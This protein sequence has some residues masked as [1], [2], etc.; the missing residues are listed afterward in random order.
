M[1]RKTCSLRGAGLQQGICRAGGVNVNGSPLKAISLP[2][3]N[4]S[5]LEGLP[6]CI[7]V[8]LENAAREL[9]NNV[10]E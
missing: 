6:V 10:S 3:I 8:L 9:G 4:D 7:R 2:R 1:L 5:R